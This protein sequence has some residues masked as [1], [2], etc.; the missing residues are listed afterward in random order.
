MST[1][2]SAPSFGAGVEHSVPAIDV[3]IVRFQLKC[4]ALLLVSPRQGAPVMAMQVHVR[5]GQSLDPA[6]KEGLAFL[7]GSLLD[8]GTRKHTDEEIAEL[9]E[10][11]GGSVGG[12]ASGMSAN[13]ASRDTKLLFELAAEVLTEPTFPKKQFDRHKERMLD[14]LLLE[15]DEPRVQAERLFRRLVYGRHWL[16]RAAYGS[17]ESVR[18]IDRTDL[19]TFHRANWLA[20]RAIVAVCGDVDPEDVRADLDRRLAKWK[21]GREL[22]T[23]PPELPERGVRVDAF[24][25][26]RQQVHVYLG[27][28]GIRRND[29]DYPALVVMDHVLGTGP[30]FTNRISQKLRDELGLAYTVQANIHGSAGVIPGMFSA[31]IA[32]SPEHVR[33]AIEGFR[34]EIVRIQEEPVGEREL[35]V[36]KDY[37]VGSFALS[38]QRASRRASY[39][40]SAERH[41]LPPDNLVRLP[42][43]FAAV[44]PADV[45]RVARA[46]LFADACCVS[47]AGPIR[48]RDIAAM[49]GVDTKSRSSGGG[50]RSAARTQR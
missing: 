13:I 6:G 5:G 33:T 10:T 35:Q 42:R 32:T 28:L 26:E 46:H 9:L 25:A 18:R 17:I 27:H 34:R 4:G 36:A 37:L 48:K 39:V 8:Q 30:G 21:G 49:M 44:T 14:R 16:G 7:T 29:P 11:A 38:F 47:A 43:D 23:T 19:V 41:R 45:Q 2:A 24:P 40:I 1:S 31:Y 15:R 20:R 12:D 22:Q 50:A 3:P